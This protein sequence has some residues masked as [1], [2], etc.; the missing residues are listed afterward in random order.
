MT[1]EV[2]SKM[3]FATSVIS[4]RVG[5]AECTIDSNIWVAVITGR[6]GAMQLRMIRFWRWGS[7]SMPHSMPRSPR[8]TMIA[9]AT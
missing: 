8:A 5:A 1:A 4:A 3:A 7:S 6:P 9:P 2:P